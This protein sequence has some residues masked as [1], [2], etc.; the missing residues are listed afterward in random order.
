MNETR[1][2]T[3][4]NK[5]F[6][7]HKAPA[8]VAYNVALRYRDYLDSNKNELSKTQECLYELLKYVE[9]E[10]GDGR[11]AKLDN[12]EIINQHLKEAK[13]LFALQKA[14]VEL[15]FGFFEPAAHSNS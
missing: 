13:S 9:V 10:L 4:E 8:T 12:P 1:R 15:N 2:I 14:T 5:S 6:I 11:V 3:L 7:I